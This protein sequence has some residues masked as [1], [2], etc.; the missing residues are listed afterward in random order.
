MLLLRS[1]SSVLQP[2]INTRAVPPL[3]VAAFT[4]QLLTAS[5]QLPEKSALAMVGLLRQVMRVHG[6]KVA[7]L[8]FSEER[9]GDGTFDPLRDEVEGSNPFAATVWEGELLRLHYCPAVREGIQ[10]LEKS[11]LKSRA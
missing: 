8:W 7:A 4:K 5:L 1:L 2:P 3:R 11:I 9:R 10:G 6:S